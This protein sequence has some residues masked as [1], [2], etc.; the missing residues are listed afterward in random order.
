MT[1]KELRKLVWQGEGQKLEFKRKAIYPF[2]IL[3]E[4]VAMANAQ[5]GVLLIGVSDEGT[6]AGLKHPEDDEYVMKEYIQK[7]CRPAVQ[8][9]FETISVT[10]DKSVLLFRIH[11]SE[12]KPIFRLYDLKK[13]IGKAYL[14]VEDKSLQASKEVRKILKFEGLEHSPYAGFSYGENERKLVQYLERYQTIT[15]DTFSKIAEISHQEASELLIR[16]TLC[17]LI[18]LKPQEHGD[19][20]AMKEIN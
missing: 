16:L 6:I 17:N 5:G 1:L 2:K 8:Y 12:Q 9:D 15:I 19:F 11:E 10:A 18:E 3:K 14:R 4:I 7:Y 13:K 20:F